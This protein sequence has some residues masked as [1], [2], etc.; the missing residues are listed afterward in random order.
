[1]WAP[2][3]Y[4]AGVFGRKKEAESP[5]SK[6]AAG[7]P[8]PQEAST[9]RGGKKNRP[10]PSRKEAEA[11]RKRPLVVNDRKLAR[12]A[13]RKRRMTARTLEQQALM[14]GDEAHMPL[15][16]KGP[17]KRFVRD[18]V[19]SRWNVGEFTLILAPIPVIVQ[20]MMGASAARANMFFISNMLLWGILLA[21]TVDTFW[22]SRVIKRRVV[23]KFGEDGLLSRPVSYGVMRG[24][25]LR[26]LRLPKPQVK[27][28]QKPS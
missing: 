27:R 18:L 24:L 4:A 7:T 13:D 12:E 6:Q 17:I 19:D 3:A 25:Q 5:E 21:I 10:T 26:R 16:H 28:G 2:A 8:K 11:A 23:E 15:Q 9:Q 1:M 22:L 14:S 20:L